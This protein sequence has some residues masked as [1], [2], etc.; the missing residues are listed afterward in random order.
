[1]AGGKADLVAVGGIARGGGGGQFALGQLA[2][3][4]LVHG[5]TGVAAAGDAHGL[6][7]I[8]P[9]G[10]RVAD[11]AADAGGRAAEGLDLGGVV[12]GLVLEHEQPVLLLAVYIHGN[13]DRAGVDLLA[14]IQVGQFAALFQHLCRR[15]VPTSIRVWGRLAAF[16]SP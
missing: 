8:G 10:E 9:A 4:R 12:V 3:Q 15:C 5:G 14:L 2:R 13:V 7:D 11:G 16:S 6:V 1:M